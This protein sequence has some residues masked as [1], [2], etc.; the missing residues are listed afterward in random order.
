M[1]ETASVLFEKVNYVTQ[2]SSHLVSFSWEVSLRPRNNGTVREL[3]YTDLTL[4]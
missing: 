2:Y 4:T 3:R 1:N